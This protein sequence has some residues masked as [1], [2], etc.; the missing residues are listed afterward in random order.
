MAYPKNFV[1][2]CGTCKTWYLVK[3]AALERQA[4]ATDGC[5][6]CLDYPWVEDGW[7]VRE[8]GWCACGNPEMVDEWMVLYLT[9]GDDTLLD[10][11]ATQILTVDSD[12][13]YLMA[14]LADELKWTEHGGSVYGAWL[15]PAGEQARLNL[16]RA[17][18]ERDQG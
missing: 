10:T 2:G 3:N 18:A 8:L 4:G 7:V 11:D 9:S 1:G 14:H 17:Y 16:M 5:P 6:K 15:T 13:D 12:V